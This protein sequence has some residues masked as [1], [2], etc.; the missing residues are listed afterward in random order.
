MYLVGLHIYYVVC[1]VLHRNVSQ[2]TSAVIMEQIIYSE[3]KQNGNIAVRLGNAAYSRLH[4]SRM[5]VNGTARYHR[6]PSYSWS[7]RQN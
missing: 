5:T 4:L 7:G 6:D 3:G 2:S 1:L